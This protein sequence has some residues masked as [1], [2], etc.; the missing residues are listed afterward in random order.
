[1]DG[2]D[3]SKVEEAGEDSKE[4]E[5]A[6]MDGEDSNSKEGDGDSSKGETTEVGAVSWG[7]LVAVVGVTN[8]KERTGSMPSIS[9][10]N[11]K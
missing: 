3:S 9:S 4:E 2:E 6:T 8:C 11:F 10:N 1:M 7:I 5:E